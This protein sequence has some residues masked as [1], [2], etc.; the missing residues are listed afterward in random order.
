[1]SNRWTVLIT[2]HFLLDIEDTSYGVLKR[3]KKY[4]LC[5]VKN[6]SW[7][8][9]S[10]DCSLHSIQILKIIFIWKDNLCK[11]AEN[12]I[13]IPQIVIHLSFHFIMS[14]TRQFISPLFSGIG[15]LCARYQKFYLWKKSKWRSNMINR[16]LPSLIEVHLQA[17]AFRISWVVP[18]K[19]R[20]QEPKKSKLEKMPF[21]F[22]SGER[23]R[24]YDS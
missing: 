11:N 23:K 19:G 1:M 8:R 17:S 20:T 6:V 2:R 3:R 7:S 16:L 12:I 13:L 14:P 15:I 9:Q 24:V 18:L 21:F 22:H 5:R 4:L 10:T